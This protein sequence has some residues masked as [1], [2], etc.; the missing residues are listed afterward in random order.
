[1]ASMELGESIAATM[2]MYF[3]FEVAMDWQY[4]AKPLS[5]L[6]RSGPSRVRP[7]KQ[8]CCI[9]QHRLHIGRK[10][11]PYVNLQEIDMPAGIVRRHPFI[12][13]PS[14]G[15]G[16]IPLGAHNFAGFGA[17]RTAAHF[18]A[19]DNSPAITFD[20][21]GAIKSFD[22]SVTGVKIIRLNYKAASKDPHCPFDDVLLCAHTRRK[23]GLSLLKNRDTWSCHRNALIGEG[24]GI[25]VKSLFPRS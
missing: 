19:G 17:K 14:Q 4:T 23:T 24:I 15:Q 2:I 21:I 20:E 22:R 6:L 12:D 13:R 10:Y 11:I 18:E 9:L 1:M 7:A 16:R 3:H 8:R 5:M 25:D